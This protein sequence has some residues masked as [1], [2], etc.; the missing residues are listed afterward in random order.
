M[1]HEII[2][3]EIP[4]T[5]SP[6]SVHQKSKQVILI[7]EDNAELRTFINDCLSDN[8]TV[9]EAK[10]GVEAMSILNS[11]NMIDIIVSDILMPEMDGLELCNQIKSNISFSHLP[12]ILLSAK[13]DTGTKSNGL[14]KGADV[15]MEKPFSIEQ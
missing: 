15:Y 8:Y 7:V 1:K 6:K 11:G 9:L 5:E 12:L 10:N 3:T 14:K 2:E 13:T 4:P